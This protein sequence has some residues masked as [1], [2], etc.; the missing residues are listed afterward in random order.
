MFYGPRRGSLL[1]G[2]P[3]PQRI[4]PE[5]PGLG[6]GGF[7]RLRNDLVNESTTRPERADRIG[8]ARVAGQQSRLKTTAAK[9][10]FALGTSPAGRG[11]PFGSPEPIEAFR[12]EPN[13]GEGALPHVLEPQTWNAGGRRT[14]EDLTDR[15]HREIPLAPSL[16]TGLGTLLVVIRQHVKNIHARGEALL[17]RHGHLERRLHLLTR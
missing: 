1:R 3:I 6:T 5:D 11:H 15:I 10:N 8:R 14:G 16:H 9:I 4:L 12:L 2:Q 13:A 17:R 7:I